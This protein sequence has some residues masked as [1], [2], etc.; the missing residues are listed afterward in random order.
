MT[1]C[2]VPTVRLEGSATKVAMPPGISNDLENY[3]D[4]P[5]PNLSAKLSS[6]LAKA[7]A[8]APA[9]FVLKVSS[10][11]TVDYLQ[12]MGDVDAVLAV[13]EK[14]YGDLA[15]VKPVTTNAVPPRQYEG[16]PNDPA[17]G[18]VPL[19]T[20]GKGRSDVSA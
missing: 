9:K 4:M 13:L 3:T 1:T 8:D 12:L 15:P 10:E 18:F 7:N 5:G 17:R 14:V 6:Y 11:P 19:F 2:N 16:V 20:C